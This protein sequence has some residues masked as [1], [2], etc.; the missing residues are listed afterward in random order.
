MLPVHH[1]RRQQHCIARVFPWVFSVAAEDIQNEAPASVETYLVVKWK[2]IFFCKEKKQ[3]F[4]L[5]FHQKCTVKQPR[6]SE[7]VFFAFHF[8]FTW[9]IFIQ[10]LAWISPFSIDVL[11]QTGGKVMIDWGFFSFPPASIYR[12]GDETKNN[13]LRPS[14]NPRM[15]HVHACVRV[16]KFGPRWVRLSPYPN[17]TSGKCAKR[18]EF[19]QIADVFM[20]LILHLN[21]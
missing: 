17:S 13:A 20:F 11:Y 4:L 14:F 6:Q 7:K 5:K 15:T 16:L 21:V 10:S 2:N 18:Q 1:I 3:S 9:V 19:L 12:F 8:N